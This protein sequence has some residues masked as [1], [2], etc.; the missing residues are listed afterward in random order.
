MKKFLFLLIISVFFT[1]FLF[2]ED[3]VIKEVVK[4]WKYWI[5]LVCGGVF[6]VVEYLLGETALIKP[7]STLAM[8]F[9]IIKKILKAIS[10]KN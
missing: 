10:G 9:S 4:D 3:P 2:A 1:A 5:V 6:V 7:N 8:I